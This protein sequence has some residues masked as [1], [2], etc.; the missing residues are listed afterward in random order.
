MSSVAAHQLDTW[1]RLH[2]H[3]RGDRSRLEA[4]RDRKLRF[5]IQQATARVP[6]YRT[7]FQEAGMSPAAIQTAGDLSQLPIS[8]AQ[9]YRER[10]LQETLA[11]GTDPRRLFLRPTSGSSGRPF[12][13]RRASREEHLI[14]SCYFVAGACG[15]L[16]PQRAKGMVNINPSVVFPDS[17]IGAKGGKEQKEVPSPRRAHGTGCGGAE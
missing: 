13:V 6:Y 17:K 3:A 7:L 4:F 9:D 1:L 15:M 12:V 10:P 16:P 14:K 5:L 2:L 11:E 8:S